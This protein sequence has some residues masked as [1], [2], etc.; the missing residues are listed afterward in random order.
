[1]IKLY[2]MQ[3]FKGIETQDD[4]ENIGRLFKSMDYVWA[5]CLVISFNFHNHLR[6]F[7]RCTSED[8]EFQSVWVSGPESL[9]SL[10]VDLWF[11]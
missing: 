6:Y 5:K 1:M 7:P 3:I 8:T 2:S 10:V 11:Q 4:N 9:S